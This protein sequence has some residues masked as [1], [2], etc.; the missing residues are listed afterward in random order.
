MFVNWILQQAGDTF[1][2]SHQYADRRSSSLY[3]Y[4]VFRSD[5]SFAMDGI[6]FVPEAHNVVCKLVR[7]I[8][9][10]LESHFARIGTS[11]SS[12]ASSAA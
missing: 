5:Q 2:Q 11:R 7:K 9:I 8:L 6:R 3:N 4:R 1:V 10:Q 12:R